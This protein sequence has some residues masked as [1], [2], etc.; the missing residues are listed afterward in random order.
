MYVKE[1]YLGTTLIGRGTNIICGRDGPLYIEAKPAPRCGGT[2]RKNDVVVETCWPD[3][4]RTSEIEIFKKAKEYGK[5]IG[6][7]GNQIPEVIC[8]LN[9]NF[10]CSPTK[11][12]RQ[13]PRPPTDGYYRLRIIAFQQLLSI[14][15]LK[16]K[17][18]FVQWFFL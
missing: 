4:S 1:I 15:K 5:K 3:E 7:I 12:I 6:L 18:A 17:T 9:Q 8:Y 16:E 13:S 14:K 11:A 2:S 10:L